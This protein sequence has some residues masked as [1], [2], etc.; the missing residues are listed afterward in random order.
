MKNL[1]EEYLKER[2][3]EKKVEE[4]VQILV[5]FDGCEFDWSTLK[6]QLPHSMDITT[7]N[8]E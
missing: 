6:V 3:H 5:Y 4:T 2:E 8:S 1:I 7:C